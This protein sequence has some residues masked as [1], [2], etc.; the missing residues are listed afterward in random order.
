[1]ANKIA[2]VGASNLDH[3]IKIYAKPSGSLIGY[4]PIYANVTEPS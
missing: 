4:I 3:V 1:M 2:V